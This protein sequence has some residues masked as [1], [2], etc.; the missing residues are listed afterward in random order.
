MVILV[1]KNF[2]TR[3][4]LVDRLN[5]YCVKQTCRAEVLVRI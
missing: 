5:L 4:C 1:A 2:L 3:E